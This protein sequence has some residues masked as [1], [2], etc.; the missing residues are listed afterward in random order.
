MYMN[1]FCSMRDFCFTHEK[2]QM[3]MLAGKNG[4]YNKVKVEL[5]PQVASHSKNNRTFNVA[6]LVFSH[7]L[8]TSIFL[9]GNTIGKLYFSCQNVFS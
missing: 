7:F 2:L 3:L 4:K 8:F 1:L 5:D 9:R 6:I